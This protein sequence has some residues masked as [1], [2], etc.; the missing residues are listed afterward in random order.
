MRVGS[1]EFLERCEF[2][3]AVVESHICVDGD[4]VE[5]SCAECF[6]FA[7]GDVVSEC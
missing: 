4:G 2:E 6:A 5:G 7:G 3:G 1:F